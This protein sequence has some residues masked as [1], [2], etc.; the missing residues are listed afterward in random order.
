VSNAP[1][2]VDETGAAGGKMPIFFMS[3]TSPRLEVEMCASG[4]AVIRLLLFG[5]TSGFHFINLDCEKFVNF[6]AHGFKLCV[7]C[8]TIQM[9]TYQF[10]YVTIE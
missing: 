9:K 8:V 5:N 1:S 7:K 10:L 6:L 3:S 4:Y 2:A